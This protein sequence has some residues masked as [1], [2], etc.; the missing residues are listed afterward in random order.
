MRISGS[1]CESK[2]PYMHI[3]LFALTLNLFLVGTSGS[4][5]RPKEKTLK[6]IKD[7]LLGR[8]VVLLGIKIYNTLSGWVLAR[9]NDARG[10]FE[11]ASPSIPYNMK[12]ARGVVVFIAQSGLLEKIGRKSVGVDAFGE[13]IK[14][15]D[16]VNPLIDLVVRLP[17][18]RLVMSTTYYVSLM[19]NLELV[20][21]FD[22]IRAQILKKIDSLIG[23][24]IY[25]VGYSCL[26]PPDSEIDTMAGLLMR[27]GGQKLNIPNL[28]PLKIV[29]AKYLD[30][31]HAI[32]LK[33][34]FLNAKTGL[35]FGDLGNLHTP[36][37][38]ETL[39]E[40]TTAH[41]V[42]DIGKELREFEGLTEREITA[43]KEGVIFKGM[44]EKALH[45][46]IGFESKKNDWGRGGEQLIYGDRIYVYIKDGKV[47][48]WQ[49][50]SK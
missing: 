14:E 45:Y 5:D 19:R 47:T 37:T 40:D 46:S 9:E 44:S 32:L 4:S 50:M 13:K 42:R 31:Q 29:R 36:V 38:G 1:A 11:M 48:D 16:I 21:R 2:L 10:G 49:I 20:S 12:G 24:T 15:E 22:E 26:F 23:K 28:T 30:N 3:I 43:V 6:E 34:E 7:E 8:E 25:P 27:C 18:G 33:V 41:F 35:I 39:F 17:D